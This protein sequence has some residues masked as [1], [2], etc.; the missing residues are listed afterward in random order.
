MPP[1]APISQKPVTGKMMAAPQP[2]HRKRSRAA[3][4]SRMRADGSEVRARRGP[5]RQLQEHQAT[6]P[7]DDEQKV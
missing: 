5:Q 4:S 7:D 2:S 6:D 1:Y 3:V